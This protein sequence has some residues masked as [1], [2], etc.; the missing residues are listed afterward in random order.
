[1]NTQFSCPIFSH[2]SA[3]FSKFMCREAVPQPSIPPM[4]KSRLMEDQSLS[5]THTHMPSC[6]KKNQQIWTISS[7]CLRV[8]KLDHPTSHTNFYSPP[9]I[10]RWYHISSHSLLWKT[11]E[12]TLFKVNGSYRYIWS[13]RDVYLLNNHIHTFIYT[14]FIL[15]FVYMH[16]IVFF[17]TYRRV[18]LCAQ[19]Y[20][21]L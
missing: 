1:M 3:C 15:R 7:T 6:S 8:M 20:I 10:R 14:S 18:M 11:P 9:P 5:N 19:M 12:V 2:V 16:S 4:T 13:R 17:I 21:I